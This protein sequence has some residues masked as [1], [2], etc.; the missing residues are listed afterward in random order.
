MFV[1]RAVVWL[2][3]EMGKPNRNEV[4]LQEMKEGAFLAH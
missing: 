1:N 4:P 2:L 3:D